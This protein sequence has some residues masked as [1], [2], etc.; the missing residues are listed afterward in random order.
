[1]QHDRKMCLHQCSVACILSISMYQH[2]F[3][4][5]GD[6]QPCLF[7]QVEIFFLQNFNIKEL[8]TLFSFL[9]D[10]NLVFRSTRSLTKISGDFFLLR[11]I[12]FSSRLRGVWVPEESAR[13]SAAACTVSGQSLAR[14]WQG[15]D[16]PPFSADRGPV[17]KPA[18]CQS[19]DRITLTLRSRRKEKEAG[20]PKRDFRVRNRCCCFLLSGKRLEK[21]SSVWRSRP[22]RSRR[23]TIDQRHPPPSSSLPFFPKLLLHHRVIF[24]RRVAPSCNAD[25][26]N[27]PSPF[28]HRMTAK[29]SF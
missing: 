18:T 15:F 9:T 11:R 23:R 10:V 1:M 6:L 2:L 20:N 19:A 22:R 28:G 13:C 17:G 16:S 25:G 26:Y 29:M 27:C 7:R 4:G 8:N 24:I 21:S 14:S 5:V 12:D 3:T